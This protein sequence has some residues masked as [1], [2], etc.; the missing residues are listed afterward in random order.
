MTV[1]ILTSS[2]AQTEAVQRHLDPALPPATIHALRRSKV[3]GIAEKI[4]GGAA[5]LGRIGYLTANLDLLGSYDALVVPETTSTL[6]KTRLG[7]KNTKLL[8]IPHGAGDRSIS[9]SPDIAHFDFVRT[10]GEKTR[11]R[12]LDAGVAR[13]D[14]SAVI[15]YPKFDSRVASSGEPIFA[16]DRPVVFYNP[17]FDPKL[18]SWFDF[19]LP[20]LE[21]FADQDKY[22][23]IVA[24]HVMLFRRRV[25]ASVEHRL[26][27]LR[28]EIPERFKQLDHIHIDE[29]S[30]NCVDM[31][32][33]RMA[34][35][36]VGDVSSQVYEFIARPR[37]AIFLNSHD[38][39][40]QNDP[41]Y[42]FWQFGPVVDDPAQFGY[43]LDAAI[44]LQ[45]KYRRAQEETLAQTFDLSED[46]SSSDR[47]AR[48]LVEFLSRD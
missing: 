34:D 39:E 40:W 24:P 33:T 14:A 38:A 6:L 42:A 36:Y 32:Y 9:F 26:V 28:K 12:M 41:N 29:G 23:L 45:D 47:A 10:P 2:D 5:P 31:T 4:I 16:N 8:F 1:D 37:P 19:G 13:A 17:H 18:S 30:L 22:N 11:Q 20:L 46:E 35:I 44:P 3:L 43:A 48:A 15:G 21:Y 27:R 25:L 7:L